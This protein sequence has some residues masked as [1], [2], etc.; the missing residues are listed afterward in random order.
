MQGIFSA[1]DG[2]FSGLSL[3]IFL[4]IHGGVGMAQ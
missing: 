2:D 3:L 4:A 1:A